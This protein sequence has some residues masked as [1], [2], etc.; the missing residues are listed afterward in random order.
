MI[1]RGRRPPP[2]IE[3]GPVS[4]LVRLRDW[5][6]TLAAWVVTGLLVH[7]ARMLLWDF[8]KPPVFQLTGTNASAGHLVLGIVLVYRLELEILA[9]WV[10]CWG[11]LF[12]LRRRDL[13]RQAKAT[14]PIRPAELAAVVGV[15][16]AT[17]V[18][19]EGV[20]LI[21]ADF[22][23]GGKIAAVRASPAAGGVR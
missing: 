11:L 15:P 13:R 17:L 16:E 7:N 6:L 3:A 12:S 5:L 2:L 8:L 9:L 4:W 20:K 14:P 18:A 19:M 10:L 21:E 22:G 1:P 23:E